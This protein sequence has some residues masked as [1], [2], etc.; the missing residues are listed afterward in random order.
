MKKLKCKKI[1]YHPYAL[2]VIFEKGKKY[3][4]DYILKFLSTQ[5]SINVYFFNIKEQRKEK[6]EKLNN[7][8]N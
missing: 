7:Y 3:Y 2:H 6:I 8:V 1:Y 5:K 4:M